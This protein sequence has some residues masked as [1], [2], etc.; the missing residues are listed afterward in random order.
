MESKRLYLQVGNKRSDLQQRGGARLHVIE[1]RPEHILATRKSGSRSLGHPATGRIQG[2]KVT[3][4]STPTQALGPC[5]RAAF[6]GAA[7]Q[8]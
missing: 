1:G 4:K 8:D 5:S 2:L 7:G 3:R 6:S